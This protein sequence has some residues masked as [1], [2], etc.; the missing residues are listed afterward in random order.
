MMNLILAQLKALFGGGATYLFL[1]LGAFLVFQ[2]WQ[3]G[4]IKSD[5]DNFQQERDVARAQTLQRDSVIASQSQQ[6]TRRIETAKEQENADE[7]IM[8]VP[9]SDACRA[10]APVASALIWLRQRETI[11]ASGDD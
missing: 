8:A 5:R 1:G 4:R 10:S 9:D 6:F 11:T 7:I 3:I 2:N